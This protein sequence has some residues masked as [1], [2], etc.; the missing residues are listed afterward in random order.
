MSTRVPV[1]PATYQ[2]ARSALNWPLL[3]CGLFA[4][5]AA[6]IAFLILA[7]VVNPLWFLAMLGLPAFGPVL[8]YTS[9]LYRNW[10]TGIRIDRSGITIG[11]VR[12]PRAMQ[13]TP[14]VSHQSWG[15]FSCPWS[16]VEDARVVTG[17]AA[18]RRLKTSSRYYT[19]T[20]R[21]GSKNAMTHCNIGVLTSPFMR[22]ALVIDVD[23]AAVTGT[24]IRPA[25]FYSNGKF[26]RFSRLLRPEMSSTWIVPTRDP[27]G[28][29]NALEALTK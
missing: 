27:E 10:P 1:R 14:N 16:A 15:I 23:P 17:P 19:L 26:G 9:L 13:R 4:P 28:L 18:V 5:A 21:W 8:I 22:A 2:E 25:R 24:P 7:V 11:A 20:N 29:S 3:T 12:S 6:E